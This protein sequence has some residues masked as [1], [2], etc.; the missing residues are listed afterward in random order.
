V[1]PQ[2]GLV[3][4]APRAI[5]EASPARSSRAARRLVGAGVD[6]FLRSYLDPRGGRRSTPRA[7]HLPRGAPRRTGFWT[8]LPELSVPSLFVW[9]RQDRLIPIAFAAHVRRAVPGAE[10]LELNCGHV[11]QLEAP[12][13][14]HDAMTAFL[15]T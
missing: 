11:P 2:L 5:V 15:T 7:Q 4:P 3:Q 14:T 10:H 13:R 8:R 9:G 6:E 1:P 12:R